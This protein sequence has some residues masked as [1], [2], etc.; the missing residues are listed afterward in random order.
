MDD[1]YLRTKTGYW[2]WA[3]EAGKLNL[4]SVGGTLSGETYDYTKLRLHNGTDE[5][6]ITDAG[7]EGWLNSTILKYYEDEDYKDVCGTTGRGGC[8]SASLDSWWGYFIKSN[9]DN[10]TLIRQN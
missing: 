4:P 9:L 5:L 2:V 3:K 7:G 1:S 6:N 10:I 8:D